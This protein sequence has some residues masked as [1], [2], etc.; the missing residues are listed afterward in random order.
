MRL[1]TISLLRSPDT[2]NPLELAAYETTGERV[3]EGTLHD[4]ATGDWF[5]IEGGIA[6]LSPLSLRD[7]AAD[8]AVAERHGL[9]PP[10]GGTGPDK[11]AVEQRAFFG[12]EFERYEKEV[13]ESPFYHALDRETL[14]RWVQTS[15]QK[16]ARIAEVGAGSGRQT[17]ILAEGGHDIVAIDLS[18]EMLRLAQKKL[19][20]ANLYANVDLVVGIGEAPPLAPGAFDAWVIVG[21]LHHFSDPATAVGKA[22]A[23]L[24]PGGQQY[25]LEPHKSPVRPI[26]DW[27]MRRSQLWH[28][29]ANEDPLF[30]FEKFRAWLGAAGMDSRISTSTFLPP[31]VFYALPGAAARVLLG[32]SDAI[33]GRTPGVQRLGGVIIAQGVKRA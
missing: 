31:H 13:V 9:T 4:T 10:Q 18:V 29:E 5:R 27:L 28:E 19:E 16:P 25:L 30:T 15:F 3:I 12:T 2:G 8:L 7:R 21:S 6:D 24:R 23:L 33:L 1:Q 11:N 26:F 32:A 17:Q 14:G 20:A 22:C